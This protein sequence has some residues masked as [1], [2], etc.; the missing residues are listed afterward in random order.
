MRLDQSGLFYYLSDPGDSFGPDVP[1][2]TD[3]Q[4]NRLTFYIQQINH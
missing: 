4:T 2:K 3:L 1:F